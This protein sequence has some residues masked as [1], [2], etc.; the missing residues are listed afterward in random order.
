MNKDKEWEIQKESDDNKTDN[1]ITDSDYFSDMNDD[2]WE[3]ESEREHRIN[4]Y[5]QEKKQ[6]D[7]MKRV[8]SARHNSRENFNSIADRYRKIDE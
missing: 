5:L 6:Q 2:D 8:R 3:S 7:K 4:E 1:D